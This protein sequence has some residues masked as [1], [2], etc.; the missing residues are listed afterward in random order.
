M[1]AACDL[2]QQGGNGLLAAFKGH[3]ALVL[4]EAA[5]AVHAVPVGDA[6]QWI[7][8]RPV[9][10]DGR[11]SAQ[12]VRV[13]VQRVEGAQAGCVDQ[14]KGR[15]DW[16]SQ[17]AFAGR[18]LGHATSC[19][20]VIGA[21]EQATPT[22]VQTVDPRDGVFPLGF[23]LGRQRVKALQLVECDGF[24]CQPW[25][26][27]AAQLQRGLRNEARQPQA[28]HGGTKPIRCTVWAANDRA[29]IGS[30]QGQGAHMVAER[31]RHMVIL[32][33]HI[34]GDRSAHGDELGAGRDGQH[35][36]GGG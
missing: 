21:Q 2:C 10:A 16:H 6:I 35:P 36:P 22:F 33:V 28:A 24:R 3:D 18:M 23:R 34:V 19:H 11:A 32:S 14:R 30:L 15:C 7:E 12:A 1:A 31:A 17:M 5:R 26:G 13:I 25:S 8:K 29:A 4:V 20:T 9:V 27:H